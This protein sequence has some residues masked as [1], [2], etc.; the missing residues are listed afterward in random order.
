MKCSTILILT[1][2]AITAAACATSD[3]ATRSITVSGRA[4]IMFVPDEAVV[5]LG[6]ETFRLNLGEVKDENDR[7]VSAVLAA[8]KQSGISV[9]DIKTDGDV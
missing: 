4:E 7:I 1:V 5:N 2:L 9:D 3:D 8:T 6:V